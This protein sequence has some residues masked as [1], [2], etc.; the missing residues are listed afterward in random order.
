[1]QTETLILAIRLFQ[2]DHARAAIEGVNN[3]GE[4]R[5]KLIDMEV[6]R[7]YPALKN[8][9]NFHLKEGSLAPTVKGEVI[10]PSAEGELVKEVDCSL[11]WC[12]VET[13]LPVSYW[14]SR[15]EVQ[16]VISKHEFNE[17]ALSIRSKQGIQYI[18]ACEEFARSITIKPVF[19]RYM[20]PRYRKLNAA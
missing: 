7:L 18:D 13:S 20:P 11:F 6:D 9:I 1:M 17:F 12:E 3:N 2:K 16:S 15:Y 14:L 4:S 5:G 8:I 10:Q 19:V